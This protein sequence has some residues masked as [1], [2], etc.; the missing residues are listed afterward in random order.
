MRTIWIAVAAILV[1]GLLFGIYMHVTDVGNRDQGG[2]VATRD[3]NAR[4]AEQSNPVAESAQPPAPVAEQPA[5]QPVT[6]DGNPQPTEGSLSAT[7]MRRQRPAAGQPLMTPPH[8]RTIPESSTAPT[9]EIGVSRQENAPQSSS[10]VAAQ[11][12]SSTTTAAL[13]PPP[14][15]VQP[16][17]STPP[18]L[19]PVAKLY[20]NGKVLVNGRLSTASY[21]LAGDWVD[22]TEGSEATLVGDNFELLLRSGSRL[23][24][25]ESG[26]QLSRGDVLV[27][28]TGGTPVKTS[29]VS[30][31]PRN[32][33]NA[34]F[35]VFD[36]QIDGVRVMTYQGAV[37]VQ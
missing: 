32:T 7:P 17:V 12:G 34:R 22:T 20:V 9:Q 8:S 14:P 27:T 23:S 33:P 11:R 13:Q 16:N 5:E 19:L 4:D 2:A 35:E 10:D 6:A 3:Q 21:I 30:V 37:Q 29:T 26:V 36:H 31:T 24:V 28:T 18:G 25:D 15:P 1:A